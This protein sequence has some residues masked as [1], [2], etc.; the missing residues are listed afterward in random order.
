MINKCGVAGILLFMFTIFSVSISVGQSEVNKLRCICIDA[1][2]GGTDPG[3]GG[4]QS[5]EKDIVLKL[6]LKVG[7]MIQQTYP[8]IKVVYTRKTDVLIDLYERGQIANKH[9]ADLFISI[10]INS[11]DS[12][13]PHGLE[14]YVLGL[15][16][17]KENLAVAMKENSVIKYE[18]DYSTKYAGFDPSRPES[19]IMFSLM[20]NLYL[21]KSLD[22]AALV[23]EEM[24][25]ATKRVDRGVRQAG[26]IVLVEAAMPAI[27]IEAGFISNPEEE[28]FLISQA[29]QNKI[30]TSIFKAIQRY[31]MKVEK[32]EDAI[33][34][35][36]DAEKEIQ[37]EKAPIQSSSSL[38]YAIQVAS[39]TA[40]IKNA[41]GL[42]S[43]EKVCELVSE[44]RYRYYVTPAEDL[45]T[46]K[47]HFPKVK[48]KVKDCF[49]IAIYKGKAI[50]VAEARKLEQKSN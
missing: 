18:E 25:K 12:R 8:D 29:G 38:C 10:H 36:E 2:H 46:V 19:Y 6:A 49:V 3:A 9:H 20:Q 11:N 33:L 32:Q 27:L 13:S 28:R 24:V 14:T 41:S 37:V 43:G 30:A 5:W 39:A 48:N 4:L 42:C 23:Q 44:G 47:K 16:R 35:Q 21:E 26:Y 31:K 45:E 34:T 22:L 15:H 50:S 40:R 17:T 7:K 1:G